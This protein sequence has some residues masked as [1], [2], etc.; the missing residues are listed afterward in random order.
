MHSI[1]SYG[2][3]KKRKIRKKDLLTL[4]F[5]FSLFIIFQL[6][7]AA[8]VQLTETVMVE[9]LIISC[10]I[11]AITFLL[12]RYFKRKAYLNSTAAKVD[13]MD[14]KKF[15]EY[16]KAIYERNGYIVKLTPDTGD[17]GAD[18][19]MDNGKGKTVVQAKRYKGT[20]GVHAVQEVLAAKEYYQ[21]KK[22]IVVTNN[23]FTANAKQLANKAGV[24]LIDRSGLSVFNDK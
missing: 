2:I 4:V 22:A 19:V 1:Y 6:V 16:L 9:I 3:R 23:Y 15:E 5:L 10:L 18:L 8:K 24:T 12:F 20:V 13:K 14:G 11:T 17:Y 21:A 7:S